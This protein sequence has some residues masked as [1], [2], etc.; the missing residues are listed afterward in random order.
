MADW[1]NLKL[2]ALSMQQGDVEL[3]HYKCTDWDQGRSGFPG[4]PYQKQSN[5]QKSKYLLCNWLLP[6]HHIKEYRIQIL[7]LAKWQIITYQEPMSMPVN[8]KIIHIKFLNKFN[9]TLE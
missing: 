3:L 1:N 8:K 7:A 4:V 6:M 2:H 5:A 9:K